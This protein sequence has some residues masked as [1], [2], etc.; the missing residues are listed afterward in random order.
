MMSGA[1]KNS[2]KTA[3]AKPK[4]V[5]QP[6]EGDDTTEEWLHQHQRHS[7]GVAAMALLPRVSILEACTRKGCTCGAVA[8]V[9]K[10]RANL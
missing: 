8:W 2:A 5:V 7:V 1:R 9:W 10:G 3:N 6:A 4:M